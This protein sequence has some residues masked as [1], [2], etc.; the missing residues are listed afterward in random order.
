MNVLV[1]GGA[2]YLG[3]M[4]AKALLEKGHLVRVL[5]NLMYGEDSISE[6]EQHPNFELV[7]GDI[8]DMATVVK[9]LK[10]VKYVVHL[11]SIVGDQA[12]SLEPRST[13]EIN[14]LATRNMAE[15]CNLY[16]IEKILYASTC[17][18]YGETGES[19]IMD[20]SVSFRGGEGKPSPI[21]LYGETKLRSER[22]ITSLCD[23]AVILRLGTLF[24]L[25]R[26]MRFDLAVNMF[27][28]RALSRQKITVFGGEQHRPFLHVLDAADAFVFAIEND[29]VGTFNVAWRNW[30]LID[31]AKEIQKYLQT[32]VEVSERIVDRRN[33]LVNCDR[34][35]QRG[36]RPSRD[37]KFAIKEI[38]RAFTDGT[39]RDY[40]LPKYSNYKL[41]FESEEVQRK[42]YTLGPIGEQL[43]T[44]A[45]QSVATKGWHRLRNLEV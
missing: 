33:Y 6:L 16:D 27:I 36:F 17:S 22:A 8:R 15:L 29:L 18:V 14:Y 1:T 38:S 9:A 35:T 21:S 42:V 11:A 10:G 25:S 45:N 2:G 4:M 26:R 34:I 39:I 41:L 12:A 40:T 19:T 32:E 37:I 44:S 7:K 23:N 5:D 31:V 43:P 28:A 13:I 30:K 3:S 20:E 24:G